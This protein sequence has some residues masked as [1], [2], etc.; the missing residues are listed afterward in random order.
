[1]IIRDR[2]ENYSQ[3]PGNIRA[4]RIE[5]WLASGGIVLASSVRAARSIANTYHQRR[6]AEGFQAW[7][8]PPIFDWDA[9]LAETWLT[10]SRHTTSSTTA[11]LLS[12]LQE[13]SL[14]TKIIRN[15]PIIE[16][17]TRIGQMNR[18][19]A[20]AQ[21]AYKLLSAYTPGQLAHLRARSAWATWSTDAEALS[22]WIADFEALCH[23]ESCISPARLPQLLTET[24]ELSPK[25]PHPPLLLVGFDRI[26][27]SQQALLETWSS[28]QQDSET[29]TLATAHFHTAHDSDQELEACLHWLYAQREANP[30]ARLMLIV[31]N[32]GTRRGELERALLDRQIPKPNQPLLDFEFSLGVPLLHTGLVR[33]ALYLIRWLH[34]PGEE[35]RLEE[36]ELDWLLL[37]THC[38]TSETE[39]LALSQTLTAIR[40]A[41]H[42]QPHWTLSEFTTPDVLELAPPKSWTTRLESARQLHLSTP[43]LQSPFDWASHAARL[44]EII[45]WPGYRPESSTA[46]QTRNRWESL[47]ESAA[48]LGFDSSETDWPGFV[49]TLTQSASETIFATESTNA[50]L[51]IT[52]PLTSAGQSAD[53]I[54]FLGAHEEAWPT[55]GQPH[56][57]IPL[58]IQRE[59]GM[60][61]SSHLADW[62]LAHQA[63]TRILHSAQEVFFSHSHHSG[64]VEQR[65]SRL[66]QQLIGAPTPLPAALQPIHEYPTPLTELYEDTTQLPFAT[67]T[68]SPRQAIGGAET[69]TA[70]SLCPFQSFA[71]K[72]LNA[73]AFDPAETGLNARQRGQLLHAALHHIWS[74]PASHRPIENAISTHADLNA[75]A[76][77]PAD[78]ESFVRHHVTAAIRESFAPGRRSSLPNRFPTRIL[79]LEAERLTRLLTEWLAYERTRLPFT[80]TA[81]E[82]PAEVT[83]AGLRLRLR[84]DRIDHVQTLDESANTT[85]GE[86]TLQIESSALILDYK[87]SPVGPSAWSGDHPDDLQLP[88]YATHA[89]NHPDDRIEGLLIAQVRLSEPKLSGRVAHPTQ[90]LFSA[91]PRSNGLVKDPLTLQQLDDWRTLIEGLAADFLNGIATVTP[92]DPIKTC[93]ACGLHTV[94][95]I[96]DNEAL[97][98]HTPDENPEDPEEESTDN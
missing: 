34:A 44:L 57:L 26:L 46:Y 91:I 55:G 80:V 31:P 74:G 2:Q 40:E 17:L 20:S 72:R 12:P 9:W 36:S 1:M 97:A 58:P 15:R 50:Q 61:H 39:W 33:S 81:T 48:A 59:S 18:L 23:R 24:L 95:R 93:A 84:L 49:S 19:A 62:Q 25:S 76:N 87:S 92:K 13:R 89:L 66:I 67:L 21:H 37:S 27:P 32:L 35:S 96:Y 75:I 41:G 8:T 53:A 47:L 69:I 94:C 98:A 63:T 38:A 71:N 5:S 29:T 42:E 78:L 3:T 83:I 7:P 86:D 45:G 90:S 65:P 68:N 16:G 11:M 4:G 52:E 43:P 22:Q 60:P 73:P 79:E 70:Q 28:W 6:Q 51:Q 77:T 82:R 64:E 14:W 56:P 54:W 10:Q 30:S 85:P 88:L